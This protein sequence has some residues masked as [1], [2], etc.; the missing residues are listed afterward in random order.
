MALLW[1][2]RNCFEIRTERTNG[3]FTQIPRFLLRVLPETPSRFDYNKADK[4][5][6]CRN[7]LAD[8]YRG[9]ETATCKLLGFFF[10]L[11]KCGAKIIENFVRPKLPGFIKKVVTSPE[12]NL[13]KFSARQ[14][15]VRAS[16]FKLIPHTVK[17]HRGLL[18]YEFSSY[19]KKKN[20]G[21]SLV[22]LKCGRYKF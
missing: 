20:G 21:S 10:R 9:R 11:R 13:L 22:C 4:N 18:K 2:S 19:C 5:S 14:I 15:K 12:L 16:S 1:K 7:N 3:E 6:I 17:C 8:S